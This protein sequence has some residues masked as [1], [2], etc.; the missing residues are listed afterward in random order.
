MKLTH[1]QYQRAVGQTFIAVAMNSRE[2][3]LS[4]LTH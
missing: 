1:Y 3:F 2:E 4:K